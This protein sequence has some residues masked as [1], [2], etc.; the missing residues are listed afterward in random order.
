MIDKKLYD[1][2]LEISR[3]EINGFIDSMD[4]EEIEKAA[5]LILDAK[6]EETELI[7]QA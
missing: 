2:F 3:R 6:K 1:S 7:Y 4:Y 5:R